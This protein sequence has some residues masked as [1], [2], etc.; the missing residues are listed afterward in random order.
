MDVGPQITIATKRQLRRADRRA[1][2]DQLLRHVA[3]DLLRASDRRNLSLVLTQRLAQLTRVRSVGLKEISSTLPPHS[4]QP[5]RA[6]DYLAFAVPVKEE[7]RQ[8]M[9]EVSFDARM[10]PDDWTCRLAHQLR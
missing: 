10:G 6:R 8:V 4:L 7:G 1:G 2:L 5:I 9:L 3:S